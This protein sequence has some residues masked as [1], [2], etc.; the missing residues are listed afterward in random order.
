MGKMI[1]FN[2]KV[3]RHIYKHGKSFGNKSL[4]IYFIENGYDYN[5][6]G[7]TVSKKLGNS[8]IRNRI[9]RLIKESFRNNIAKLKIGYDIIFIARMP[10]KDLSYKEIQS[11]L[12]HVI[13][14]VGLI[15]K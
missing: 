15:E 3:F 12:K 14:K 5:R 8:V 9:K 4:V 2:N 13:K 6:L 7:I 1:S 10:C 11:A